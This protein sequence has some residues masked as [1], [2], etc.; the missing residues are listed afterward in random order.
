MGGA[1]GSTLLNTEA[2]EKSRQLPAFSV[3]ILIV[4]GLKRLN[5]LTCGIEHKLTRKN[6]PGKRFFIRRDEISK[7]ESSLR[8]NFHPQG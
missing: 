2:T 1:F 6:H 7:E 8:E 3:S 5:P 4:V